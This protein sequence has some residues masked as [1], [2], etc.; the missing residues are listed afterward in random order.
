MHQLVLFRSF[1]YNYKC[2]TRQQSGGA[3]VHIMIC[4]HIFICW[5]I[6]NVNLIRR[7]DDGKCNLN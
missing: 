7:R 1:F 6:S 2:F 3:V 4:L 5:L